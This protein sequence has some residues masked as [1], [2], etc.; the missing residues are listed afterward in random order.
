MSKEYAVYPIKPKDA[1]AIMFV[2]NTTKMNMERDLG[3]QVRFERVIIDMELKRVCN[4]RQER[5]IK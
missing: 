5:K 1:P 3:D 4:L 2:D